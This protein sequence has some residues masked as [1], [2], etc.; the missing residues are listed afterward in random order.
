MLAGAL[1]VGEP[2]SAET[3][4]EALSD[5][6]L[7]NPRLL[8]ER[9]RQQADDEV[10]PQATSGWR[11]KVI[12]DG[13]VGYEQE[14][15]TPPTDHS[16]RNNSTIGLKLSQPVFRGFRTL[17]ETRSAEAGVRAGHG[18]LREIEQDVLLSAAAA[19]MN[20]IRDEDVRRRRAENVQ[21]LRNEVKVTTH[22]FGEGELTRTDVNQAKTRLH[23][24]LAQLAQAKADLAGSK[25]GF[26]SLVG[27]LPQR[28]SRPGSIAS[29]LPNRLS[30][31][32]Q[33]ALD[34]NPKI[35]TA[36]YQITAA[37]H[38]VQA[39][40]GELLPTIN[41]DASYERSHNVSRAFDRQD[42]GIVE[43]RMSMPLYNS[44]ITLSRIRQARAT[45]SQRKQELINTQAGIQAEVIT[46]W[47][48]RKAAHTRIASARSSVT[49]AIASVKG[50][51]I[52]AKAGERSV[53]D[54]LDAQRELVEARISLANA[55]RDQVVSSFTLLAAI[56]RLAPDRL[57]LDV[58][59]HD[60]SENLHMIR[61]PSV[62][63]AIAEF[64]TV[65]IPPLRES[66]Y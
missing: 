2:V 63:D 65:V 38:D 31:A 23:Q 5:A 56:G 4:S 39:V 52:E 27:H 41:L 10:I 33:V 46:A 44:G 3:L 37:R 7:N 48:S 45:V 50:I 19:Y 17:N 24:G 20:I 8:A 25:A 47:E 22:K 49:A 36:E 54:V 43:L 9:A 59:I 32:I 18:R 66:I 61:H 60:P 51:R 57:N 34:E 64:A 12:L 26:A 53:S 21:F 14:R 62:G 1:I 42:R 16:G 11:P 15:T 55:E 58:T 6:Y 13:S 40:R 29:L 28:L 35:I 30:E